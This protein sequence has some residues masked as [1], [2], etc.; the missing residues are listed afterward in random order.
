MTQT[1]NKLSGLSSAK[2]TTLYDLLLKAERLPEEM[3]PATFVTLAALP[4]TQNSKIDRR[5]LPA[6]AQKLRPPAGNALGEESALDRQRRFLAEM[7]RQRA[8]SSQRPGRPGS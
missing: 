2:R 1:Q 5:A 6:P 3:I 7:K 4:L 8:Q